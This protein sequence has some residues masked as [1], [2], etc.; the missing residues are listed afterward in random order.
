V[1]GCDANGAALSSVAITDAD[2]TTCSVFPRSVFG[3]AS[4]SS[5]TLR[6]D[7]RAF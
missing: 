1:V 2:I 6:A 5:V 3:E 7:A 4:P